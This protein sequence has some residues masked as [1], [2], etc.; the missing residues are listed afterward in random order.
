M[1]SCTCPE[2]KREAIIEY[3]HSNV[4]AGQ[5]YYKAKAI[6]D[7]LDLSSREVGANLRKLAEDGAP[8]IDIEPWSVTRATTWRVASEDPTPQ[9]LD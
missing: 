1:L 9:S 3:L 8:G 2:E 6:A 4:D 5:H 7:A